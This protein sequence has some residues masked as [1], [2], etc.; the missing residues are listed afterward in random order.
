M[1]RVWQY[2]DFWLFWF[3]LAP[4]RQKIK[5]AWWDVRY[6]KKCAFKRQFKKYVTLINRFIRSIVMFETPKLIK[7][8]FCF[9][10]HKRVY[11]QYF[12]KRKKAPYSYTASCLFCIW[13]TIVSHKNCYHATIRYV[14]AFLPKKGS[15]IF[16]IKKKWLT[17]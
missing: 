16:T 3:F 15:L 8:G 5:N 4:K 7:K 1:K 6:V 10:D 12:Q 17:T 13:V 14:F 9:F 11:F 2:S